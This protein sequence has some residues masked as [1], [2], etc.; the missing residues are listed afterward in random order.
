MKNL[1]KLAVQEVADTLLETD[2]V[3]TTLDVKNALR[4]DGYWAR[5]EAVSDYMAEL[6]DEGKFWY[7][8]NGQHR[9][10]ELAPSS[11]ALA[12]QPTTT[13]VLDPTM[14]DAEVLDTPVKGCW[15]VFVYTDRTRTMYIGDSVPRNVARALGEV[16]LVEPYKNVGANKYK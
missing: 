14:D 5:Q 6:G 3:T 13:L 2:S 16:T 10:Y 11:T 15:Q 4:K 7:T 9:L 8:D 1:T 12:T